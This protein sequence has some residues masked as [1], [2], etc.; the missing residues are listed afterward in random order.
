MHINENLTDHGRV[1]AKGMHDGTLP[2]NWEDYAGRPDWIIREIEDPF[3]QPPEDDGM[4]PTIV[5][6][7][8]GFS[9]TW[10]RALTLNMESRHMGKVGFKL[11]EEDI[12]DAVR[13]F[14][15]EFGY[16]AWLEILPRWARIFWDLEIVT[17]EG[18][19]YYAY[20][21]LVTPAWA[22]MVGVEPT[23]SAMTGESYHELDGWLSGESYAL[24]LAT[25]DPIVEEYVTDD[26]VGGFYG[27][28][29]QEEALNAFD[30]NAMTAGVLA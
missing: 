4:A 12:L 1:V 7:G 2:I 29:D 25:W 19:D 8:N 23:A 15:E 24:E 30:L 11:G 14:D 3:P 22:D 9:T 5:L 28:V 16:K 13:R 21:S 27:Q 18:P 26:W 20:I 10:N 17:H 6:S